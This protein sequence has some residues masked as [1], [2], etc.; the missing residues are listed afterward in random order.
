MKEQPLV[1]VITVCLN[2]EK[3]LKEA[4]ESVLNQTYTNIEYIFVDGKSTD[5][6]LSIIKKYESKSPQKIRFISEPDEGIYDA[7]NKGIKTA[8]GK[9]IGILNSDDWYSHSAVEKAIKL[10]LNDE[11]L[12]IVHGA[13][14]NCDYKGA[15]ESIC[16]FRKSRFSFVEKA[17]FS[18]P[19]CFVRRRV[20]YSKVGFFD[21]SFETSADYDFMLQAYHSESVKTVYINEIITHFRKVGITSSMKIAPVVEIFRVLQKNKYT[22]PRIVLGIVY[23]L[24]RDITKTILD[25]FH[26]Y[27]RV[28]LKQG[29]TTLTLDKNFR[30]KK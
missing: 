21:S 12:D 19:T 16:G 8:S 22:L 3:Y 9:I 18:H 28:K 11:N 7:M 20:Y 26:L 10:F 30:D 24:I 5:N 23:R 15:V 27:E 29:R 13:M 17:P 25:T 1:S 6:T 2:S 14:A 4:I